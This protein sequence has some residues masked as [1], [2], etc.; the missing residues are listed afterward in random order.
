MSVLSVTPS[1]A[2]Q[3]YR[4]AAGVRQRKAFLSV[5]A[6][7]AGDLFEE[8][9]AHASVPKR[10]DPHPTATELYASEVAILQGA[11]PSL[12]LVEVT[13]TDSDPTATED[14]ISIGGLAREELM[15]ADANG[16]PITNTVGEVFDA[17]PRVQ[18]EDPLVLITKRFDLATVDL[19]WLEG[20]ADTTNAAAIAGIGDAGEVRIVGMPAA[21]K[22]V[23]S[24]GSDSYYLVTFRL[25]IR[26]TGDRPAG[27]A[28]WRRVLN[29]GYRYLAGLDGDGRPVYRTATDE[30]G[31]PLNRPV[32][33]T[34][35]GALLP[36]GDTP[37]FIYWQVF[38]EVDMDPLG[39][40]IP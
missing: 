23:P 16:V 5:L 15:E 34:A 27:T 40:V 6:S 7:G 4:T 14:Q 3:E 25:H 9:E 8:I 28:H 35:A 22:V 20:W 29:Q 19:E 12:F 13:Y 21:Q 10:G 1:W 36:D 17:P 37:E 31:I 2:S 38:R 24:D 18:Y 26:R 32:L 11:G 33:L 39:F 30:A